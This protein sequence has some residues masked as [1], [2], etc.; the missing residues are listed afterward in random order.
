MNMCRHEHLDR[1]YETYDP[2]TY[3]AQQ[4]SQ[5]VPNAVD[6]VCKEL[7]SMATPGKGM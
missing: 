7:M 4:E 2:N 3:F 1:F 6:I 5:F